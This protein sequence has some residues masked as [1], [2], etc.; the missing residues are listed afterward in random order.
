MK[1]KYHFTIKK[2]LISVHLLFVTFYRMKVNLFL[3]DGN[4]ML[5]KKLLKADK[6]L[7]YHCNQ[8]YRLKLSK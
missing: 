4:I 8:V 7:N 2:I 1:Q 6:N 5:T 3:K